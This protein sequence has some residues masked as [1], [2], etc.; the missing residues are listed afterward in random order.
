[1][2]AD[3]LRRAAP[4][5]LPFAA[6][7]HEDGPAPRALVDPA[8]GIG[9]VPDQEIVVQLAA[10]AVPVESVGTPLEA[11]PD[12]GRRVGAEPCGHAPEA[13]EARN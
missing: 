1:M 2:L 8:V 6:P 4:V 3:R 9:R 11:L 5:E 12:G 13:G 7:G 10:V